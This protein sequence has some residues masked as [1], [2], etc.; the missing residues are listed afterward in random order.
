LKEGRSFLKKR[1][2]K[3]LIAWT[4]A[5]RRAHANGQKFFA[6]FF[7]KRRLCLDYLFP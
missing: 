1:T 6:S 3:L 5:G 4:G 7:Q 2:Q